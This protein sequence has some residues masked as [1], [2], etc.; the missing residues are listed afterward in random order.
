M[1]GQE[2]EMSD[3]GIKSLVAPR[4]NLAKFSRAPRQSRQ[5]LTSIPTYRIHFLAHEPH[6]THPSQRRSLAPH[7]REVLY[8]AHRKNIREELT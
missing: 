7:P 3:V 1:E 2:I 5:S 8:H 6:T 4:N